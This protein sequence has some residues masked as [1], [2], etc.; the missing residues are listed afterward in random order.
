MAMK[1]WFTQRDK[2]IYSDHWQ[3]TCEED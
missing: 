2:L 1:F 3:T